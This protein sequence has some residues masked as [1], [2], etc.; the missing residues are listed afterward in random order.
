MKVAGA[1]TGFE[2]VLLHL[3]LPGAVAVSCIGQLLL[4]PVQS[5]VRRGPCQIEDHGRRSNS[6]LGGGHLLPRETFDH[7]QGPG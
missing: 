1:G 2:L 6:L 7:G 4:L 5:S 3:E